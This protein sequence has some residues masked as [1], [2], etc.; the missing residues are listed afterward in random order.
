[1]S[2]LHPVDLDQV[3]DDLKIVVNSV[4]TL[5]GQAFDFADPFKNLPPESKALYKASSPDEEAGGRAQ[6]I[7][8]GRLRARAVRFG[9]GDDEEQPQALHETLEAGDIDS[10]ACSGWARQ[11]L[12]E[13]WMQI[14]QFNTAVKPEFTP[15]RPDPKWH[16]I[17]TLGCGFRLAANVQILQQLADAEKSPATA[18]GTSVI[19]D[20]KHVAP[21]R[22]SIVLSPAEQDIVDV[23][24]EIGPNKPRTQ[25]TIFNALSV[26]GKIPSEGTTKITLAA[27]CAMGFS[28]RATAC[29]SGTEAG[30]YFD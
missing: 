25:K 17:A 23:V 4:Q 11:F 13:I 6:P 26:K 19:P 2:L 16:H 5:G 8:S 9:L 14:E 3:L 29:L 1:M 10:L 30:I 18:K 22:P 15:G 27:L 12:R 21:Q 28:P 7:R 20:S 24:R